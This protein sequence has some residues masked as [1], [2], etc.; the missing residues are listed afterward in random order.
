MTANWFAGRGR[1]AADEAVL[2]EIRRRV[3]R[4]GLVDVR[5][6]QTRA[7]VTE[8]GALVLI[9]KVPG[10]EDVYGHP[11]LQ[12]GVEPSEDPVETC[13]IGAWETWGFV[14]DAGL[15]I[16]D[17][18]DRSPAGLATGALH[19]LEEQLRR[20][21]DCLEW[22]VWPRRTKRAWRFADDELLNWESGAGI[23]RRR[24]DPDRVVRL[25]GAA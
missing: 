4:V 8:D 19:W 13:L 25:R 10:L 20:P 21:V 6:E 7:S 3:A 24:R 22:D 11:E 1:N 17:Y 5:P 9:V 15:E 16:L 18:P 14:L 23:L 12:V 2:A